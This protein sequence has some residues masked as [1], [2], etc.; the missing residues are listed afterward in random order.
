MDWDRSADG[1]PRRNYDHHRVAAK[2]KHH[3]KHSR[4][5]T[6]V[7]SFVLAVRRARA[8]ARAPARARA[9][10]RARSIMGLY[11]FGSVDARVRCEFAMRWMKGDRNHGLRDKPMN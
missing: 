9:R 8:P 2:K 6:S 10:A 11:H 3:V 4:P 1:T 5:A 7:H